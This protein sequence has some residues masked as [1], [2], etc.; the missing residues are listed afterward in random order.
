M[1]LLIFRIL[2]ISIS[3]KNIFG[4]NRSASFVHGICDTEKDVTC[5]IWYLIFVDL[6]RGRQVLIHWETSPDSTSTINVIHFVCDSHP[7]HPTHPWLIIRRH[8]TKFLTFF[9]IENC[10]SRILSTPAVFV[11][12]IFHPPLAFFRARA[13]SEFG[14]LDDRF[15][16]FRNP[17]AVAGPSNPAWDG[18]WKI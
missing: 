12:F 17:F 6:D 18:K 10:R 2:Q 3:K 7:H 5:V 9:S 4:K 1:S 11:P 14:S 13:H 16:C 8:L 15:S